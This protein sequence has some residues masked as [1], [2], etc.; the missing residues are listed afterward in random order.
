MTTTEADTR[1]TLDAEL[2]AARHKAETAL[3][4]LAREAAA[5][6]AEPSRRPLRLR[7]GEL[8]FSW[9]E[10]GALELR[11]GL[12]PGGF[13]TAVIRELIDVEGFQEAEHD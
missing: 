10:D 1:P 4:S 8:G 5:S 9:L 13:A 6:G 7:V 12:R 2:A 3:A 11:F